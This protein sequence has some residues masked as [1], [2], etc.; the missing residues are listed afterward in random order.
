MSKFIKHKNY[1]GSVEYSDEDNVL[2]GKVMFIRSL[3]TYE[4]KDVAGLKKAFKGSVDEYLAD[5]K[6]R[7]VEPEVPL[8]GSFN[9]RISAKLHSVATLYANEHDTSLNKIVAQALEHE[10]AS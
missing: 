1:Y 8:K 10:L 2:H 9:V 3:I 5:C 7:K 6:K 4:A